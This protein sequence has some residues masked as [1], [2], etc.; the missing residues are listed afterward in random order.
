[1]LLNAQTKKLT[2]HKY[3]ANDS[4]IFS[5]SIRHKGTPYPGI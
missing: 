1:M 4:S 5:P 3:E 2:E